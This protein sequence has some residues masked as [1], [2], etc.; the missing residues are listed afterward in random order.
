MDT[1]DNYEVTVVIQVMTEVFYPEKALFKARNWL[2]VVKAGVEAKVRDFVSKL[3][4]EEF[5][6]KPTEV[7]GDINGFVE[8]IIKLSTTDNTDSNPGFEDTVGMRIVAANLRSIDAAPEIMARLQL[9]ADAKRK[10]DADI[11]LAE[12]ETKAKVTRSKGDKKARILEAEGE[13]IYIDKTTLHVASNPAAAKI[14]AIGAL[15]KSITHLVQEGAID[16][17]LGGKKND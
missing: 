11:A 12:R 15:P 9:V 17:N 3:S 16:I 7:S 13:K 5:R 1:A 10:G 4:Y 2:N 14:A 6:A 8:C